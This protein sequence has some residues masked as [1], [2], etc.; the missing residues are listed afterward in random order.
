[1]LVEFVGVPENIEYDIEKLI[2]DKNDRPIL[3]AAIFH[4]VDVIITGD[5]DFLEAGITNPKAMSAAEFIL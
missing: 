4:K 2:R 5:K 1:M 3:R